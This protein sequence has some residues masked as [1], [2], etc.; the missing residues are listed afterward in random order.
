MKLRELVAGI[1]TI[2]RPA[3]AAA[4]HAPD[5]GA[6]EILSIADDSRTVTAGALYVVR[7]GATGDGRAYVAHAIERGAVAVLYDSSEGQDDPCP[8]EST[9]VRVRLNARAVRTADTAAG[10]SAASIATSRLAERLEGEPSEWLAL[11][12]ITGTNGKTTMAY[13][14]QQF[15]RAAGQRCG[16]MGTVVVDDGCEARSAGLTTPGGV[17]AS[18]ALGR[19]VRN[20]C[21]ACVMEVSSHALAQGR[22]SA[23][24]FRVGVFSNLTGDHLDYHHTMEEYAAAKARLFAMLPAD[25]VAVV[26]ADDPWHARMLGECRARVVRCTLQ[27][28]AREQDSAGRTEPTRYGYAGPSPDDCTATIHAARLGWQD[29]TFFGPFGTARVRLPLVGRHNAMNAL[30]AAVAAHA[31][32]VQ[33]GTI[34]SVLAQCTAPPGRLEPV[35]TPE[36]PFAVLVD[37]AH[38]DDALLNVLTALGP[39][40]GAG[41]RLIVVFGCGGDRDRTKRPRMMRVA[42]EHADVVLVTSDNPRTEDPEAII[43]EVIAGR[44]AAG[45]ATVVERCVDRERAIAEAVGRARPGDIV[46]IAGKGHEDYQ[47][48]GTVKR[49]FDDRVAAR[50]ALG[51]EEDALRS[52]SPQ[53][54]SAAAA[55]TSGARGCAAAAADTTGARGCAGAAADLS[56]STAARTS[57]A[58]TGGG[59]A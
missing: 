45:R 51:R 58:A 1:A 32:G 44:P 38:T 19:M 5:A 36:D 30:Q 20:G 15:V 41:G 21:S 49:P 9:V 31:L 33:A 24:R 55:D 6:L 34:A 3:R 42:C 26:N 4:P 46:L 25:G 18:A 28:E 7:P 14:V 47:I 22:V 56:N 37:Y 27:S 40:V 11:V 8:P 17:E 35:T 23:L 39:L 52:G 29:V 12:G 54:S 13:L 48:I 53:R 10:A 57:A 50:R 16:L 59:R 2:E 43:T